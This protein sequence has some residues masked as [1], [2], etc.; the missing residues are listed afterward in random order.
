[1]DEIVVIQGE[2][3][4]DSRGK[5]IFFNDFDMKNVRRFYLIEHSDTSTVRAWQGHKN[6]KKWFYVVEGSFKIVLVKP[7]DWQNPT[8]NLPFEEYNLSASKTEI[9]YVPGG[10]ANGFQSVEPKSKIMVFSSFTVEE[11]VK[12][13]LRFDKNLWYK[14]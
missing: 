12:D 11:S 7:D 6:E 3:F 5:L 4:E 10:Y 1:M 9:L 14:W 8:L 2:Q 13:D